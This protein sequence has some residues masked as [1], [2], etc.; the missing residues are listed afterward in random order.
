[1]RFKEFKIIESVN[2]AQS[3][4]DV[5]SQITTD[6]PEIS[7]KINPAIISLINFLKTKVGN[8]QSIK[9]TP[10]QQALLDELAV[11]LSKP[12]DDQTRQLAQAKIAKVKEYAIAQEQDSEK[13]YNLGKIEGG[14]QKEKEIQAFFSGLEGQLK[15]LASKSAPTQRIAKEIVTRFKGS[16]TDVVLRDQKI[17]K[18]ELSEFLQAGIDGRVINMS[19]LVKS[20]NGNLK[21]Y[22][23]KK[24]IKILEIIK[25]DIFGY[26][27]PGTGANMGP[28]E[29]ALTMFGN[30]AKKGDIGDLDIGGVM[31]EIKGAK[32]G[33]KSGTGL[34]GSGGRLNGTQVQKPTTGFKIINDYFAKNLPDVP[35]TFKN[36]KGK[37]I[38]RFNWNAK[39]IKLFN[40]VVT[41]SIPDIDKRIDFVTHFMLTLWAGLITNHND[42]KNFDTEIL[43][44]VDLEEGV[45]NI[46]TAIS[47]VTK[48]LYESYKLSNGHLVPGK[49]GKQ[50]YIIVLNAFTLNYVIIRNAN[51]FDAVKIAGSI[52]WTD[53]NQSTS[54][55]LFLA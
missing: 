26:V 47:I 49:T 15:Q 9:E 34:S 19:S 42:I 5:I 45:I 3:D 21:T 44:T 31:Y 20:N 55:Q 33:E 24:F 46:Q 25:D 43:R 27:P 4:L 1:M 28:G 16:F 17:S 22:V 18:E 35:S 41:E 32:P 11:L 29:V 37:L 8:D 51:D 2:T 54:P 14:V 30:P 38:S 6:H 12:M 39:G 10:Q 48:L 53:A 23:D 36:D 52:N 50:L 40:S 13:Q 7:N